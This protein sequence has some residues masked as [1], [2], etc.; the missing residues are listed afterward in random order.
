MCWATFSPPLVATCHG[1]FEILHFTVVLSRLEMS[2][3]TARVVNCHKTGPESCARWR[4]L[5]LTHPNETVET[6]NG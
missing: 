6:E 5:T 3:D 1:L 4:S 2:N